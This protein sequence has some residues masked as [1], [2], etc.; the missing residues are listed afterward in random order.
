MWYCYLFI[1]GSTKRNVPVFYHHPKDNMWYSD[2]RHNDIIRIVE[3]FSYNIILFNQ[4]SG[5]VGKF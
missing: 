2:L 1:F 3:P 4:V 5:F